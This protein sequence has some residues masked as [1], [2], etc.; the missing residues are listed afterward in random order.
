MNDYRLI[1]LE[2]RKRLGE[3]VDKIYA[4]FI[5]W[6]DMQKLVLLLGLITF[7]GYVVARPP[8]FRRKYD[9]DG[10][11]GFFVVLCTLVIGLFAVGLTT[12]PPN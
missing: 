7:L 10:N 11:G 3:L 2:T 12:Y 1:L 8:R 5:D 6:T 4:P 9:E